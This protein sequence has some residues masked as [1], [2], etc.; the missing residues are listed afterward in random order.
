ML[1]QNQ[2][3]NFF[4]QLEISN[5]SSITDF[6]ALP[7]EIL[8]SGNRWSLAAHPKCHLIDSQSFCDSSLNRCSIVYL[9]L[10]LCCLL[11]R[12]SMSVVDKGFSWFGMI[13][14]PCPQTRLLRIQ[15][16]LLINHCYMTNS[17]HSLTM[18]VVCSSCTSLWL[19]C[20]AAHFKTQTYLIFEIVVKYVSCSGFAGVDLHVWAQEWL[21]NVKVLFVA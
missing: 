3:N 10:Y 14:L 19:A 20:E 17:V 9:K 13:I 7:D 1:C 18:G 11:A 6:I 8:D 21:L 15:Y 4:A 2:V 16:I 5:C 12:S